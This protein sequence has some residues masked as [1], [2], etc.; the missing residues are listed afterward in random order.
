MTRTQIQLPDELYRRAKTFAKR[1][2]ISLAE[3][4]RRGLEM[5][6][7]RYPVATASEWKLPEV[8]CG[9]LLVPLEEFHALSAEEETFR[10]LR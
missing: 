6:L 10:S 4:S 8:D 7:D 3:M 5:F 9:G 1:R 2:E